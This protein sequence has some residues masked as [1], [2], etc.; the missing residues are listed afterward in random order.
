MRTLRRILVKIIPARILRNILS[1]YHFILSYLGA[2]VYGFPSRKLLVIGVTG[3]KGK[4]STTEMLDAIFNEA[5]QKTAL[6]NSI[7]IKIGGQ[8]VPNLMRMTMPG[9]FFIQNFLDNSV[10]RGCAVA[11]I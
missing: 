4:S 10:Q 6:L 2:L 11:I 7:R 8:S 5:G 1:I 3:T 9:R